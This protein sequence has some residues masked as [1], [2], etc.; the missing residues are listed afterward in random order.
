MIISKG[1]LTKNSLINK[2]ILMTKI[3]SGISLEIAKS[4]I[5]LGAEVIIAENN[6]EVGLQAERAINREL[7]TDRAHFI[8]TDICNY[9]DIKKLHRYI[10]KNFEYLNI[11]VNNAY[12][13]SVGSIDKIDIKNWDSSYNVNLR[14]PILILERFLQDMINRDSGT[15]VFLPWGGT[16]TN[17]DDYEIFNSA[18]VELCYT[19]NEELDNTNIITYSVTSTIFKSNV[20]VGRIVTPDNINNLLSEDVYDID[21]KYIINDEA[22]GAGIAASIALSHRYKGR[23]I[24]PIEP[25]AYAKIINYKEI[26][27][28]EKV[29]SK[30]DERKIIDI[31][32]K[33]IKIYNKQYYS[34]LQRN[35]FDRQWVLREFRNNVG[36]SAEE[37]KDELQNLYSILENNN[38]NE[39]YKYIPILIKL[40]DYYKNQ[41]KLLQVYEKNSEK[42]IENTEYVREKINNLQGVLEIL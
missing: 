6:K 42:L 17:M 20:H 39:I 28:E 16:T 29:F 11:I 37:V 34:W 13:T 35:N 9:N 24:S 38:L 30:D 15:I 40:Q 3:D 18:Q 31:L 19:L 27:K 33:V 7:N 10:K 5:W 41:L 8:K 36:L 1:I 12:R 4:L 26:S 21:G 25:L 22:I 32:Q 14:A 2:N 23:V